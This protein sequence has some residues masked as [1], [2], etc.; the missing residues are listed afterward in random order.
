[1]QYFKDYGAVTYREFLHCLKKLADFKLPEI[2]T[3]HNLTSKNT[4]HLTNH[5]PSEAQAADY[6]QVPKDSS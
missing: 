1:M 2:R 5:M 6:L 3:H 4:I